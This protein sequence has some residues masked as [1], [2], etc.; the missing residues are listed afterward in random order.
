MVYRPTVYKTG[1]G[2]LY[3]ACCSAQT[4]H[5]PVITGSS[6]KSIGT[7]SLL[8]KNIYTVLNSLNQNPH[9]SSHRN[10]WASLQSL[11]AAFLTCLFALAES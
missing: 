7:K 3:G 4:A 10:D 5:K 11:A 9:L 6:K 1:L 8:S 2:R